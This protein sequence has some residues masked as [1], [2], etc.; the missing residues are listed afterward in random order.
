MNVEELRAELAKNP[1]S[2]VFADLAAELMST[3]G[4]RAEAREICFRGLSANPKH[5]RGRL[6]LAKLFYLD[7]MYEFSFRELI[8]LRRIQPAPSLDRLI[9]SYGDFGK[10]YLASS[11]ANAPAAGSTAQAGEDVLGEID[12]EEDFVEVL[13]EI[14]KD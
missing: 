14:E 10:A 8:E 1:G 9:E 12:L 13:D 4:E 7:A 5:A 6:I 2:E 3:P 11:G